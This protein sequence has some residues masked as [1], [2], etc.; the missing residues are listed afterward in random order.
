M[1]KFS[2]VSES[3]MGISQAICAVRLKGMYVQ[4][5][6]PSQSEVISVELNIGAYASQSSSFAESP[7]AS[8]AAAVVE[9]ATKLVVIPLE[10]AAVVI[11]AVSA[12]CFALD[13]AATTP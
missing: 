8:T 6:F 3:S 13:R 2:D 4:R 10:N 7:L 11:E 9:S 12:D 1:E 5:V